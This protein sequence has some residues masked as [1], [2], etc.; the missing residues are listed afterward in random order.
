MR[1]IVTLALFSFLWLGLNANDSAREYFKFAKFSYDEGEYK[2]ALVFIN[3]AIEIDSEYTNGL[4]LRAEIQLK[5]EDYTAVI[6]DVSSV[7]Q[8]TSHSNTILSHIYALRGAAYYFASD[9]ER[10][11]LDLNRSISF[12]SEEAMPHFYLGLIDY[13]NGS[14]F[15]ALEQFDKAIQINPNNFEYYMWRAQTKIENYNPIPNTP[16]FHSIMSDIDQAIG[17]NPE[18]YRAYKL[19]C[20]MLKLSEDNARTQYID[21]L[22]RSIA[23]FP[24]Q[25]DFYAQRGMAKML[26]YEFVDALSDLNRAISHGGVNGTTLRNRGLC[27]HNLS[28][29][30]AAIEDYSNSI[31]LLIVKFKEDQSKNTK[32]NLAETFVMRGRSYQ[33]VGN[34][35]DACSDFYN[36]AKLGSKTGLNNYRRS[37][38][39]FN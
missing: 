29:Y 30:R 13:E 3:N 31:E 2:K 26:E 16:I 15:Q 11:S 38:S 32:K 18:D 19:R 37:C 34:S 14:Y 1:R 36:A 8:Q 33:Q 22:S 27:H 12:G 39:I 4:I 24:E 5:L 6:N 28:N 20:D 25:A 35:D 21:E 10:A 9:I 23:L 7:L 17:H